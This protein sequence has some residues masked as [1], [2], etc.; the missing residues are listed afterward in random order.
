MHP[1]VVFCEVKDERRLLK[2]ANKLERQGVRC[3]LFQEPDIGDEYTSLATEIVYADRR[4]LFKD[5]QLVK[6]SKK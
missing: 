3:V 6:E 1:N 5:L 4:F 2:L